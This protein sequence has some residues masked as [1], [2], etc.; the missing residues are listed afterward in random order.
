MRHCGAD[1]RRLCISLPKAIDLFAVLLGDDRGVVMHD[2]R[3]GLA[4]LPANL[5]QSA[6][7]VPVSPNVD[8]SSGRI[9]RMFGPGLRYPISGRRSQITG[10]G[11]QPLKAASADCR[12]GRGR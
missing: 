8:A 3:C 6:Q 2:V 7:Y 12:S 5:A 9:V 4:V 10:H 1:A 11:R